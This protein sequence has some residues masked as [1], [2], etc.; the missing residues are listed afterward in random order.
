MADSKMSR[1]VQSEFPHLTVCQGIP[2]PIPEKFKRTA[3]VFVADGSGARLSYDEVMKQ[4]DQRV[5]HGNEV[6]L[7]G[8]AD[9]IGGRD[10]LRVFLWHGARA[11]RHFSEGP[12]MGKATIHEGE[13]LE[14]LPF[15]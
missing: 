2:F 1:D 13:L 14:F 9:T 10:A 8:A 7:E 12:S 15:L 11:V 4:L 3:R 6:K 5:F